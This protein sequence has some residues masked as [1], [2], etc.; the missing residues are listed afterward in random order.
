M[1]VT[2]STCVKV[3]KTLVPKDAIVVVKDMSESKKDEILAQISDYKNKYDDFYG[4]IYVTGTSISLPLAQ[5]KDNE[6]YL[7]RDFNKIY[8]MNGTSFIDYTN[9]RYP[10]EEPN[11]VVYGHNL[12]NEKQFSTLFN[13]K[14]KSAIKQ[15][16]IYLFYKDK[17]YIYKPFSGYVANVKFNYI[18]TRFREDEFETL[19]SQILKNS[20]TKSDILPTKEDNIITLS[21]CTNENK[22]ERFVINGVLNETR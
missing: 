11:L 8:N 2:L 15:S 13:L 14:N 5:S 6:Y 17:I 10:N 3:K 22:N 1:A 4:W 18:Q 16:K 21:T 19:L 12:E 20:E 9:T 7:R